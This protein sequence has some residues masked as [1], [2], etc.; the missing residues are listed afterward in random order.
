MFGSDGAPAGNAVSFTKPN[1]TL[2]GTPVIK[3]L[4][5]G[6]FAIAFMVDVG[7]DDENIYTAAVAANGTIIAN[8]TYVGTSTA[9]D[10]WDPSLIAL[11]GNTYAVGWMSDSERGQQY[12]VEVIGV[13][14]TSVPPP[15]PTPNPDPTPTSSDQW[16]G[17]NGNDV[18][19]GTSASEALKGLGGKDMID[20][21]AGNDKLWG[22][23]GNDSLM[24]GDGLDIF[25]FDTKLNKGSNR[26][27]IADYK[28]AD[29]S[30]WLDNKVFS[31]LGKK[32]SE[33]SPAKLSKSVFAYEKAKDKNDYIVYSKKKG[34]ISYDAD[35]SGTK[36]KALEFA[37]VKKGLKLTHDDFFVI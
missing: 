21:G 13:P 15:N 17:T 29:D 7:G 22:G 3:A 9:G 4:A 8:T 14:G 26:D 25:V 34:T 35:G 12:V 24:G 10:Q 28:V 27:M 18:H 30:I 36:Y 2:E 16:L 37:T 19:T 20:G 5:S 32:G 23:L 33:A 11:S 6:G 31:K 1:G